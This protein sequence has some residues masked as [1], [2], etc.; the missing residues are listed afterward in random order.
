M[1]RNIFAL[2]LGSLLLCSAGA[3]AAEEDPQDQKTMNETFTS[4]SEH[5]LKSACST[6]I[7]HYC[8]DVT[9]GEGRI[10]SC[11]RA[12]NDKVSSTCKDQMHAMR[13]EF[14]EIHKACKNDVEKFCKDVE[15]G[16]GRI[17][18]C[19][20]QNE[21]K[22]SHSCREETMALRSTHPTTG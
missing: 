10:A 22:L 19:L 14:K 12:Y 20:K 11:L 9:P 15:P 3:Y 2:I 13:E 18:S 4:G 17:M 7:K 1:N 6:D 8:K 21:D 5:A 16:K